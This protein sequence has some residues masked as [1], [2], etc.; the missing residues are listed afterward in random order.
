MTRPAHPPIPRPDLDPIEWAVIGVIL[1]GANLV[2]AIEKRIE[3][4]IEAKSAEV[5]KKA[6][7]GNIV[8]LATMRRELEGL[9]EVLMRIHKLGHIVTDPN[10]QGIDAASLVFDSDE[11]AEHYKFLFDMALH[12]IGRLNRLVMEIDSEG[13]PFSDG[14]TKEFFA[15]P[16]AEAKERTF[17]AIHPE[18]DAQ[19]RLKEAGAV[20][21][22][23][24][25][26]I[27]N[28]ETALEKFR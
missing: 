4:R 8:R 5:R 3:D 6:V 24:E 23:Y 9:R 14:D 27:R 28:L 10:K 17:A 13:L 20:L 19:R 18:N 7:A 11:D 12:H 21:E 2:V 15:K 16:M 1:A 25:N 22:L 26:M